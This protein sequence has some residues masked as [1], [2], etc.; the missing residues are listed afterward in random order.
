[1][2]R[3]K[4]QEKTK[5]IFLYCPTCGKAN[6]IKAVFARVQWDI[7]YAANKNE[8]PA[9]RDI[10]V[11]P[12]LTDYSNDK[13]KPAYHFVDNGEITMFPTRGVFVVC[14]NLVTAVLCVPWNT[15]YPDDRGKDT[16]DTRM[17]RL[18]CFKGGVPLD[19][20]FEGNITLGST[21]TAQ[22]LGMDLWK[23]CNL[24]ARFISKVVLF[25]AP[26]KKN[27]DVA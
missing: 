24:H 18:Y 27:G 6:M 19:R 22:P 12:Y 23:W 5:D 16:A 3:G 15:I 4:Q 1:M 7:V 10:C 8:F 9:I 21:E 17:T 11:L 2:Q 13:C 26:P 14:G 20:P 25:E